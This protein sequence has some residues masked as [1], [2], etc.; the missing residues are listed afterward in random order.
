[1][2]LDR[3]LLE[4]TIGYIRD[5]SPELVHLRD[6]YEFLSKSYDFSEEQLS[7]H[8]QS[9]GQVEPNWMHDIRNLM[10]PQKGRGLL[11]NPK[12]NYW[13]IAKRRSGDFDDG[14]F[15]KLF[16]MMIKQSA[17]FER[18]DE[19]LPNLRKSSEWFRVVSY[20]AEV[21]V[22]RRNDGKEYNIRKSMAVKHLRHLAYCGESVDVG[23][24]HRTSAVESAIIH[25]CSMVSMDE[26]S[27]SLNVSK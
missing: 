14:F 25:L 21:I 12:Q 5:R 19:R 20:S 9:A 18:A 11:V 4:S 8:K 16:D 13:G 2:A 26:G 15:E 24:L 7:L 22:I 17:T 23:K 27:I 6:V 1:M 10:N 3:G